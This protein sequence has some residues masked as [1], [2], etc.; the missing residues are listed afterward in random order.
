MFRRQA[1]S[2]FFFPDLPGLMLPCP[3]APPRFNCISCMG[4]GRHP[5]SRGY[6]TLPP[7]ILNSSRSGMLKKNLYGRRVH[8]RSQRS[9]FCW[10]VFRRS[11]R[12]L[13]SRYTQNRYFPLLHSIARFWSY[14][15]E[16]DPRYSSIVSQSVIIPHNTESIT[17]VSILPPCRDETDKLQV[18]SRP[19]IRSLRERG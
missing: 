3:P 11:L 19:G 15:H 10:S 5:V 16:L 1:C 9:S 14:S 12:C 2:L 4:L 8:G 6:Q 7:V 13:N 17:G 18:R